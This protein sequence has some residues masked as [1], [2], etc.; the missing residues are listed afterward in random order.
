L[1]IKGMPMSE[2]AS[3]REQLAQQLEKMYGGGQN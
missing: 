2:F 3:R 1:D